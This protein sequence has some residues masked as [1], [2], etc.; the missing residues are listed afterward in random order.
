MSLQELEAE[1]LKLPEDE[2]ALLAERLLA[3]L[4]IGS[5]PGDEDPIMG[6][7]SAPVS[8]DVTDGS[9]EHDRYLYDHTQR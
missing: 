9:A 5:A 7:G 2:R 3:S 6:L 4:S 8:C 1:A